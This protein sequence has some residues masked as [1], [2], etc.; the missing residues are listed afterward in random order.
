VT[1]PL[2]PVDPAAVREAAR[3][4]EREAGR[5]SRR[6]RLLR[7]GWLVLGAVAVTVSGAAGVRVW[8]GRHVA[9]GGAAGAAAGADPGVTSPPVSDTLARAPSGVRVKVEVVNATRTRGLARRAT[10]ALRDRG[11]DVVA[12]GTAAEQQDSTVVLD[13][14]GHPEW[15][16]RAARAMGG[17]RVEARPDSSR[18]LDL[19]VLVGRAWRP[20]ADPL[21]P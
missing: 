7:P 11:Y 15:A 19:T 2:P 4:A 1:L 12:V 3:A 8:R 10:H 9:T 6:P 5:R 18:Y 16:R 20:P 17:A 14:S 21:D 13:R